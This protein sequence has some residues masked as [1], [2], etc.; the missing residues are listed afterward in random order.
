MCETQEDKQRPQQLDLM[1]C[2]SG[3]HPSCSVNVGKE[4]APGRWSE[5]SY[6][7]CVCVC[8]AYMSKEG[9]KC[10]VSHHEKKKG[11]E[12]EKRIK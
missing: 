8:V 10:K 3:G 12:V 6:S 9:R 7:V 5:G 4:H 1:L 11:R 2:V